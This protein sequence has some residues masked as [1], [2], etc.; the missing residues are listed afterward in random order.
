[1]PASTATARMTREI[2]TKSHFVRRVI[3]STARGCRKMAVDIN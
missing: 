2:T 3:G 1:M